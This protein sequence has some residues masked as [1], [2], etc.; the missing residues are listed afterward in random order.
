MR[1]PQCRRIRSSQVHKPEVMH[2]GKLIEHAIDNSNSTTRQ[3]K[4]SKMR[5]WASGRWRFYITPKVPALVVVPVRCRNESRAPVPHPPQ[6]LIPASGCHACEKGRK[7]PRHLPI[8][9]CGR[10]AT[11]PRGSH[12]GAGLLTG[13]GSV[14]FAS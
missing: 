14:R 7:K 12:M 2:V 4:R 10:T 13:V 11:G 5:V 6:V 8:R 1:H 3:G 9:F